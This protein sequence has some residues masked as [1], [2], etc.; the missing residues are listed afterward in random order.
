MRQP[1]HADYLVTAARAGAGYN[2]GD[3]ATIK[4]S[5][6]STEVGP[7]LWSTLHGAG[8]QHPRGVLLGV[9]LGGTW[10]G[11]KQPSERARTGA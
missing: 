6:G 8:E 10:G 1:E 7:A 11:G 5:D 4:Y 2:V 9:L 3:P